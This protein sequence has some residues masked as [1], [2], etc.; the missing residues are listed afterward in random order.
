[1]FN[2]TENTTPSVYFKSL[3]IENIR[4]FKEKQTI[5]FTDKDGN[6]AQWTVILG[7][8]NTGKTTLLRCLADMEIQEVPIYDTEVTMLSPKAQWL[9]S[10]LSKETIDFDLTLKMFF[11]KNQETIS[12]YISSEMAPPFEIT[13][14]GNH[15][16]KNGD[17]EPF[18]ISGVK[19]RFFNYKEL[20]LIKYDVLRLPEENA[21]FTDTEKLINA[22]EWLIKVFVAANLG[23]LKNG[24][25][26]YEKVKNVLIKILPDINDFDIKWKD[27]NPYVEVKSDYGWTRINDLGYGYQTLM[28]W[29]VDL[30]KKMFD[31][32][33]NSE[34]PLEEPAIV[35]V[36]EIDLHLH[37]E[38]QRK[39]IQWLTDFFPR[40]QFIVTAHSPL[41]VQSA[42]NINVVL[43]KKEEKRGAVK[44]EQPDVSNFQGWT[45]EEILSELM[46]LDNRIHSDAYL[47]AMRDFDTALD[48]DNYQKA[49]TAYH[50]LDKIL[51]PRSAQRKLM[52]LQMASLTP[53]EPSLT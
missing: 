27:E 32:Y 8:N 28:A 36:D 20:F 18:I 7:N 40:T 5:D 19:D 22:E 9:K 4:C 39:I 25:Q 38:W 26:R 43:L 14:N 1:M 42:E 6:I 34:K 11:E 47:E 16:F 52:R 44:I 45:V 41:V 46:G 53:L 35:L 51:H 33:P 10:N 3:E 13:E 17:L 23:G 21:T 50:A 24:E 37:P 49:K 29:V 12:A 30:A 48:E 31:R 15:I 2:N